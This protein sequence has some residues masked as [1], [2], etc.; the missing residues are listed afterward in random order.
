MAGRDQL[1][2]LALGPKFHFELICL[3]FCLRSF[4]PRG[5]S[6]RS[7]LRRIRP[8][9]APR[10]QGLSS[11]KFA[12]LAFFSIGK[13]HAQFACLQRSCFPGFA[14]HSFHLSPSISFQSSRLLYFLPH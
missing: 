5:N 12:A 10:S 7:T 11:F 2:R 13:F 14:S 8:L 4:A 1:L 3:A 9:D 6:R